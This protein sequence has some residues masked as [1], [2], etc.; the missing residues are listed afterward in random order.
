MSDDRL[1]DGLNAYAD[2]VRRT[3]RPAG[4]ADVRRRSRQRKQRRAYAAAFGVV[5]LGE[6]MSLALAIGIAL[7]AA[8]V[9]L[10]TSS[11]GGRG[12]LRPSKSRA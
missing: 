12:A 3:V 11:P 4:G 10:A 7:V 8:A 1:D 5:L 6:P 9:R 2:N